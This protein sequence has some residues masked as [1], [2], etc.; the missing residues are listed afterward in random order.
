MKNIIAESE[1]V[2]LRLTQVKDLDFVLNEERKVENAK[3]V[4]QWTKEEHIKALSNK[5]IYHLIIEDIS[6]NTPVG[7]LIMAGI[8]NQSNNIEFKRLVISKKNKGYGRETLRLVKEL[9]FEKLNAHR[10]WLDVRI[11]NKNAQEIYLSEGFKE[12][13]TLRECVFYNGEYESIIIMSILEQEYF[14]NIKKGRNMCLHKM[15][16]FSNTHKN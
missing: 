5:D 9:S 3:Y 10:L 2:V 14:N 12:E 7:Y 16:C 13:G 6:S 11:S 8:E 1:N 15:R 4:D